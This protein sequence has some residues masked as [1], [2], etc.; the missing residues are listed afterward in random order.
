MSNGFKLS[1]LY[2]NAFV[3]NIPISVMIELLT[4]CNWNCK[5]CY[6]PEHNDMGLNTETII[7]LLFSL[8]EVGTLNVTF[9]GGEIFLRDDIFEIIETAR[10]LHFRV[11]L[12]SNASLLNEEKIK[13]LANLHISEF[14]TSIFSLDSSIHDK[15]TGVPGSLET[16]LEN[17]F[18]MKKYNLNVKIKTPLMKDNK[19]CYR[20]LKEF[21]NINNFDYYASPVVFSKSNGDTSTHLLRIKQNDLVKIINEIDMYKR[22]K[23]RPNVNEYDVPCAAIFYGFSIDCKGDVYPCNSLYYKIGNILENKIQDIWN[24]SP[25]LQELKKIK[26]SDLYECKECSL[27]DT[28]E[29]CPGLALLE[30]QDLLGCSTV[31]KSLAIARKKA[32]QTLKII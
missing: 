10:K 24:N 15:I 17:L 27:K 13:K 2:K 14:S 21:C 19:F 28:C 8:R 32:S 22:D 25:K 20:D 31:A 18:L 29:R 6:I 12:L 9:T 5:H 7:N 3:N 4:A 1:K 11:F 26:N 30:D 16:T 23:N